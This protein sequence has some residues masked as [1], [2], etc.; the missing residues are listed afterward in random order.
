M[1]DLDPRYAGLLGK[2]NRAA[3]EKPKRRGRPPVEGAINPNPPKGEKGDFFKIT[4]SLSPDV[5]RLIAEEVTLRKET[6]AG[7]A[8]ASAIIREAIVKMLGRKHGQT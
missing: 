5:Y 2:M 3:N 1:S 6:K 7:N 8:V 4:V